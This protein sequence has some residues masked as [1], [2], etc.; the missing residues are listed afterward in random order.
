MSNIK[1]EYLFVYSN[2]YKNIYLFSK[3]K[4][5]LE[6]YSVEKGRKSPV[7]Y[8]YLPLEA[9]IDFVSKS[10]LYTVLFSQ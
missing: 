3:G 6:A 10:I 9:H 4:R 8:F 2:C 1:I 5:I 7:D